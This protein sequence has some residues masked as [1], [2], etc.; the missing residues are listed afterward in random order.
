[1]ENATFRTLD[2]SEKEWPKWDGIGK[3]GD[4][5]GLR[6]DRGGDLGAKE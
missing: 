6:A 2:G 5:V 4:V 1:M 3:G